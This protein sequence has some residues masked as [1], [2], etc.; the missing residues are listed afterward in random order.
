MRFSGVKPKRVCHKKASVFKKTKSLTIAVNDGS[1]GSLTEL[2]FEVNRKVKKVKGK[3]KRP[4]TQLDVV[5]NLGDASE[6]TITSVSS[7]C[8]EAIKVT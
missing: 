8:R 3:T 7:S 5:I 2:S 6:E 4:F 1:A